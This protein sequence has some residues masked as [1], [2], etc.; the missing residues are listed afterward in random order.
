[1]L[2]IKRLLFSQGYVVSI[3]DGKRGGYNVANEDAL[4]EVVEHYF[5]GHF[6]GAYRP[7]ACVF[8]RAV[9][10][11]APRKGSVVVP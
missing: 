9:N 3:G 6:Q 11:I 1:M 5:K 8:C 2:V 7:T 4:Q 10:R